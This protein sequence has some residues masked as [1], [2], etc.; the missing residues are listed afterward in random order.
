MS[1]R[2][3]LGVITSKLYSTQLH[4]RPGRKRTPPRRLTMETGQTTA[5]PRIQGPYFIEHHKC[6]EPS[7]SDC[8][9]T[10]TIASCWSPSISK[11]VHQIDHISRHG[12]LYGQGLQGQREASSSTFTVKLPYE[13]KV[14]AG[15]AVARAVRVVKQ[16]PQAICTTS[17]IG[18]C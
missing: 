10:Y 18:D 9:G 7:L 16:G 15:V 14:S 12:G 11:Y 3:L 1:F 6:H 2:T 13:M 4:S 5:A 17:Y 8:V